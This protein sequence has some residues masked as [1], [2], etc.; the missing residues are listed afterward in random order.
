MQQRKVTYSILIY[1]YMVVI[2]NSIIA[3]L[4][5]LI[6]NLIYTHNLFR[7]VSKYIL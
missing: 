3:E 7:N 5:A 1:N 4:E 6:D 2:I